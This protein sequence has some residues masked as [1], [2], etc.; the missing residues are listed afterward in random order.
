MKRNTF[1]GFFAQSIFSEVVVRMHLKKPTVTLLI[2]YATPP[3]K[4]GFYSKLAPFGMLRAAHFEFAKAMLTSTDSVHRR[5]K[6]IELS[7]KPNYSD[8]QRTENP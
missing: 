1:E 7:N 5:V 8:M 3:K 2:N 4:A 6:I